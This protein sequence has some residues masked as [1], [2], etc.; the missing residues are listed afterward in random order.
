MEKLLN[1]TEIKALNL[2]GT[3]EL[4]ASHTYLFLAN[5]MSTL[6][7]FGAEKMFRNEASSETTHYK[8]IQQFMSNLN[9]EISVPSLD[10]V[11]E[12]VNN[13]EDALM[14]AFEMERDLLNAY[15]KSAANAELTL[16]TKLLLQDF[17]T[18][19]VDAVG[20]YTDLLARL[21]LTND[22]LLFDKE[23]GK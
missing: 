8:K 5:R 22:M 7:Y 11:E 20:E 13:I 21:A 16:K 9:C 17:T 6:G 2:F 3:Y 19:Q 10:S 15:E 4:T 12:E 14:I 23:L 1:E 18:H